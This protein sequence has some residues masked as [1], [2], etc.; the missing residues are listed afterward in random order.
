VRGAT[1][2]RAVASE[3]PSASFSPRLFLFA[4]T[5]LSSLTHPPGCY[6]AN[7]PSP[8]SPTCSVPSP[9]AGRTPWRRSAM[10]WVKLLHWRGSIAGFVLTRPPGRSAVDPP[11]PACPARSSSLP[12]PGLTPWRR[13]DWVKVRICFT[14]A[15]QLPVSFCPVF[16]SLIPHVSALRVPPLFWFFPVCRRRHPVLGFG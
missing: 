3:E 13:V 10:D 9:M 16:S 12:A 8:A 11:S 1:Q 2:P 5:V 14:G 6:A 15:D 7:P 4:L